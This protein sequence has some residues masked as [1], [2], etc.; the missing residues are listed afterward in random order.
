MAILK[1]AH[2]GH[3]I[4]RKVAEP[5]GPEQLRS[6][7][8]QRF[9]DDLLETMYDQDGVGLAA[10]QVHVSLRVVVFELKETD[11]PMWLVNPV[12]SLI[13]DERVGGYEGCLS[14]P[15]MRGRVERA[16]QVAV[17]ALDREGTPFSFKAYGWAARVVQHECDHL[18]GVLYIDRAD[19]KSLAFLPEYR[20]HGP[21]VP[22]DEGEEDDEEGEEGEE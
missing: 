13:G 19:P 8:F 1:V 20:R 12:V 15:N 4:L 11:G 16:R 3:P 6:P 9:C 17:Q 5:I 10:P 18:D 21:L 2:M 14:V 22:V 7:E